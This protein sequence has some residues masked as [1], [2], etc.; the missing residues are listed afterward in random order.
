[1]TRL[2]TI[3]CLLWVSTPAW[4][5][6]ETIGAAVDPT[7]VSQAQACIG[8]F[9]YVQQGTI[10][11]PSAATLRAIGAAQG[12]G[13][14]G[15]YIHQLNNNTILNYFS[16]IP[17]ADLGQSVVLS[18]GTNPIQASE[19]LIWAVVDTDNTVYVTYRVKSAVCASP[20]A[21]CVGL[22]KVR[23]T[24]ILLQPNA[25]LS[26]ANSV[27]GMAQDGSNLYIRVQGTGTAGQ[28]TFPALIKV[29]KATLSLQNT[30]TLLSVAESGLA[31]PPVF[32]PISNQVFSS[33]GNNTV[34]VF[35]VNPVAMT[36]TTTNTLGLTTGGNTSVAYDPNAPNLYVA[37]SAG[38]TINKLNATTGALITSLSGTGTV[39]GSSLVGDPL[40]LSVHDMTA[41]G[42]GNAIQRY[43][44]PTLALQNVE[45]NGPTF[46]QVPAVGNPGL[47][48]LFQAGVPLQSFRSVKLC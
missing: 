16:Q 1:M 24:A 28:E 12:G 43:S 2:L 30:L 29:D 26:R 35:V 42:A 22:A 3:V 10:N 36:L 25:V 45:A 39:T 34:T 9:S 38:A 14:L 5:I 40:N 41:S 27:L 23:G 46:G 37:E 6:T 33:A 8:A 4:A 21:D 15:V 44:I 20:T 32:D 11:T 31:G 18:K 19:N 17:F 13:N 47:N 7:I 48:R